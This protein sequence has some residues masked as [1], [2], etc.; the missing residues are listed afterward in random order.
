M[1]NGLRVL[2][3]AVPHVR[4]VSLGIWILV[5]SRDEAAPECGIS[6]F[7]EHALFKG[8]H[9]RSAFDIANSLESL[10]GSL[11]AFTYRDMTCYYARCLDEHLD[12]ALDVLADMLQ[13]SLLDPEDVEKEKGVVLEE[14]QN[15][16]DT[17]EDLIHDLFAKSVWAQHPVGEPILG[18]PDAVRSLTPG[19][20]RDYLT[21]QYSPD[22]IIVAAAGCLDHD[23]LVDRI[24]ALF[25]TAAAGG[26]DRPRVQ[27]LY[28]GGGQKHHRREIGQTHICLGATA[29]AYTHPRQ[30]DLLVANTA[31]GGGMSSRLFQHVRER[32]GLAYSVYSYLESLEDT[33]LFVTYL[34]CDQN[35][36]SQSIEHVRSE[37]ARFRQE[38]IAPE[39]LESCKAQLRGEL[40]LGL[41]SMDARMGRIARKEAYT[42]RYHS[43]EEILAAIDAVTRDGVREACWDLLNDD[44]MHLIQVGP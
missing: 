19:S 11:D 16:Q 17:P 4:S 10:G 2:T 13:N 25:G 41:E 12:V 35:R 8:T 20:L 1:D 15:V 28:N 22:R 29:Y 9:S 21:R 43:P 24:S 6:H 30:Y 36:A 33:G 14:I 39:E 38:G 31:L 27:P 44:R 5:G 7:L 40:V 18:T 26:F 3:E 42:G 23:R 32:L 37:L 34:A